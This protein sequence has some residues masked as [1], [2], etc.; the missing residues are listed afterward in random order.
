ML[1]TL[2]T[3]A[4]CLI[5]ENGSLLV[6][7]PFESGISKVALSGQLYSFKRLND[8]AGMWRSFVLRRDKN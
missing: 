5:K 1:W 3:S 6:L 7:F 8:A 2:Y 4:E